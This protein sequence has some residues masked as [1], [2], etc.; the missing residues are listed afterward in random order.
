[1]LNIVSTVNYCGMQKKVPYYAFSKHEFSPNI[2]TCQSEIR[3]GARFANMSQTLSGFKEKSS[4]NY[5]T[6]AHSHRRQMCTAKFLNCILCSTYSYNLLQ[7]DTGYEKLEY[8]C[9]LKM[10]CIFQKRTFSFHASLIRH[11]FKRKSLEWYQG[12]NVN[13]WKT[14]ITR[15][16][17]NFFFFFGF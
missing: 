13:A 7:I 6:F 17:E 16:S 1:M 8:V 9:V 15:D 2:M 4:S 12:K 11:I 5:K 10:V 14:T 3:P